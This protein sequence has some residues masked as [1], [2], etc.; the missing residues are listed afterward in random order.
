MNK[1][2]LVS[3]KRELLKVLEEFKDL[4]AYDRYART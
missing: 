2:D 4:P 3:D 1:V